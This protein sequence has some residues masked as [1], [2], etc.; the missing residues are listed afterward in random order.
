M[1]KTAKTVVT[2]Y[3]LLDVAVH[4]G[5]VDFTDGKYYGDPKLPYDQAQKNQANYLLDQARCRRGSELLDMGCGYGKVLRRA[6][7]RGA[8]ALGITVSAQQ[9]ERCVKGG[10]TVQLLN[11]RNIPSSWNNRFDCVIAN[12][13]AE[14]FVQVK[15]ALAGR[16]DAIYKEMFSI[17]HRIL[18]PG[19]RF[20]TTIMHDN[21]NIDPA[22]I[23]RGSGAFPRGSDNFHFARVMLEDFGGWYPQKI[24]CLDAQR[25]CSSLSTVRMEHRITTG[26]PMHGWQY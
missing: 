24:S 15:D 11:Y 2:C 8:I 6:G 20:V 22:E 26:P 13:S 1:H 16:A 4:G 3:D 12:G 17:C 9:V 23:I 19:G 10:L 21:S 18:K 7:A 14:H 5:V 25:A